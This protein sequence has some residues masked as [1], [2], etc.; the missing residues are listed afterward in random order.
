MPYNFSA[1]LLRRSKYLMYFI[2][3]FFVAIYEVSQSNTP[4]KKTCSNRAIPKNYFSMWDS[5][6]LILH[7]KLC[8]WV[9]THAVHKNNCN[10]LLSAKVNLE[11]QNHFK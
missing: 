6:A 8:F 4:I 11:L 2:C 10:I 7:Y 9:C 1:K 3:Y 5:R